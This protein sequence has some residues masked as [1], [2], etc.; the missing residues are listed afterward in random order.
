M[1]YIKTYDSKI[2]IN[3]KK[4]LI[5]RT[6]P[7]SK[8][9]NIVSITFI[10]NLTNDVSFIILY[11]MKET[12]QKN[13]KNIKTYPLEFFTDEYVLYKTNNL[14]DAINKIQYMQITDK[15]NL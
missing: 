12:L 6:H 8:I 1:K 7:E 10:S 13:T 14:E 3:L 9:L 15:Y 2:S 11:T 4:Y 5:W